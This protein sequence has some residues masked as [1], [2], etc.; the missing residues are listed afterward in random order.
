MPRILH[1]D[2]AIQL[3]K[4]YELILEAREILTGSMHNKLENDFESI[5]HEISHQIDQ[6][7]LQAN[8]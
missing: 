5:M 1:S 8:K 3:T 4:A 7:I 2:K 6:Y